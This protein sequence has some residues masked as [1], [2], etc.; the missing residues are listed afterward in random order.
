MRPATYKPPIQA[1]QGVLSPGLEQ[2]RREA[3]HSSPTT[4]EITPW[5]T[6]HSAQE[7]IRLSHLL[8]KRE[9]IHRLLTTQSWTMYVLHG[10]ETEMI[11]SRNVRLNRNREAFVAVKKCNRFDL[12]S[13]REIDVIT[14][15]ACTVLLITHVIATRNDTMTVDR[16]LPRIIRH[17]ACVTDQNKKHIV[18]KPMFY[19]FF[20]SFLR[21]ILHQC[22]PVKQWSVIAEVRYERHAFG[23]HVTKENVIY[24]CTT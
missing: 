17:E 11:T 20:L 5:M 22:Q 21:F 3:D 23:V 1:A 7:Q 2:P 10:F 16:T 15:N 6:S 13:Y 9:H 19:Y 12:L 14:S 24:A 18:L 4:A 8:P